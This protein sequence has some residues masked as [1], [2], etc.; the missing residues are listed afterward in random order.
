MDCYL[1]EKQLSFSHSHKKLLQ[2]MR[3]FLW[4]LW[5]GLWGEVIFAEMDPFSFDYICSRCRGRPAQTTLVTGG[6]REALWSMIKLI[7]CQSAPDKLKCPQLFILGCPMLLCSWV[8]MSQWYIWKLSSRGWQQKVKATVWFGLLNVNQRY[9]IAGG[10]TFSSSVKTAVHQ[11]SHLMF[12]SGLGLF[13][14][15]TKPY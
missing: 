13:P 2:M 7:V 15:Q 9:L 1:V 8:K 12:H 3:W 11:N 14:S 6:Y 10:Q 5:K 4:M